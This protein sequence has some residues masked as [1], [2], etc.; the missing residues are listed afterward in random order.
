MPNTVDDIEAKLDITLCDYANLEN[1]I[2]KLCES[3]DDMLYQYIEEGISSF[4][5]SRIKEKLVDQFCKGRLSVYASGSAL[6]G[7]GIETLL[8]LIVDVC[9]RF[10]DRSGGRLSGVVFKIEH[11]KAAGRLA[12][13]KLYGGELKNRDIVRNH[14]ANID[15]KVHLIRKNVGAKTSETGLLRAGDIGI[16]SGLSHARVGDI[17]GDP[18]LV[19]RMV[20][21]TAPLLKARIVPDDENNYAALVAAIGELQAEDPL[22]DATWIRE[23]RELVVNITGLIQIEIL[24][25][26]MNDRFGLRVQ[27]EQPSV[28]YKETPSEAA[29][30]F[31]AYT[32]PKPCWAVLK[33]WI[34]PMERGSGVDFVSKVNA[35][36]ILP[37]YQ[38]QV[39]QAL[40]E[41]LRQ[42]PM[43]WEVT[44]LRI[45]LTDGEHHIYHTH[46]LDFVVATP[47]A[48]MN[49][50]VNAKTTLLEPM[51]TYKLR[52]PEE[53][54][55]KI[56]GEM[57]S[58][59]GSMNDS[60]IIKDVFYMEGNYPVASG[61]YF[62]ARLAALTGGKA[63]LS[64]DFGG[65]AVCPPEFGRTTPYVGVSPLD[66]AKYILHVRK[67]L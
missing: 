28:I 52:A 16:V 29:E 6:H 39:R 21:M 49:G 45:T 35:E 65:Y 60:R 48:V 44:D 10:C 62:P 34:E 20:K 31:E 27:F 8:T 24:Q 55:G 19:G 4:E 51:Y 36:K 54:K 50:L 14:S 47:M 59:R 5:K 41:A 23:K 57:V 33:L 26:I 11:E 63:V 12:H 2:E 43:G 61:L 1:I 46:P 42:G 30:G 25:V 58:M 22:L 64:L 38:A 67:A 66:R 32:M 13:V 3:D 17:L 56:I 7:I 15:E 18:R 40:P 37:A 9:P 53:A